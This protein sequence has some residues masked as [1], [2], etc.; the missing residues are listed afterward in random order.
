MPLFAHSDLLSNAN[1]AI[2]RLIINR[3][4]RIDGFR[5]N[6]TQIALVRKD[7]KIIGMVTTEDVL[8]ELVGNIGENTAPL[9][10]GKK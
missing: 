7:K 10:E 2:R 3:N 8:E 9:Q 1:H 4:A 6:H 5:E